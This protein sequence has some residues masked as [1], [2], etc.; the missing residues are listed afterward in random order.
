MKRLFIQAVAELKYGED[1][2]LFPH[3]LIGDL[4]VFDTTL[5]DYYMLHN[6][7]KLLRFFKFSYRLNKQ[8]DGYIQ[9]ALKESFE[10]DEN[11]YRFLI[12]HI[13]G[14]FFNMSKH[15]LL[16]KIGKIEFVL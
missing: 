1:A 7:S 8:L 2:R 9:M 14:D 13:A 4:I 12:N 6:G 11:S 10:I 15:D 5:K 3:H 16:E